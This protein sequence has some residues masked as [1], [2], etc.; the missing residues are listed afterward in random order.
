MTKEK[1]QR[2]IQLAGQIN[3]LRAEADKKEI[4]LSAILDG[5]YRSP[6]SHPIIVVD[7]TGKSK[8]KIQRGQV[9]SEAEL[10]NNILRTLKIAGNATMTEISDRVHST[11]KRVKDILAK[12]KRKGTVGQILIKI[13]SEN[14]RKVPSRRWTLKAE[15]DQETAKSSS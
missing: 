6:S 5:I 1:K 3:D 7:K 2:I 9:L 15:D 8:K 4:E 13:T 11:D 14:N 12:L 10:E